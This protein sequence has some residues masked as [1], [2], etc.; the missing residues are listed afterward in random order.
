MNLKKHKSSEPDV[1]MFTDTR[2][3]FPVV[4][5]QLFDANN[6][7]TFCIQKHSNILII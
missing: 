5:C 2:L 4:L 6:Q 1:T 3:T 7:V